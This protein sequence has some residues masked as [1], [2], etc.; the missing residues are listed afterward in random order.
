MS[1][2]EQTFMIKH[3]IK[4]MGISMN[5]YS[6]SMRIHENIVSNKIKRQKSNQTEFKGVS[7][8]NNNTKKLLDI[9][10]KI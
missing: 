5:G 4:T 3:M 8:C 1:Q 9:L 10:L 7:K 2:L 6:T